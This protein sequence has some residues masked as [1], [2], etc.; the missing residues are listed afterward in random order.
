MMKGQ[1]DSKDSY[2]Q[3][4]MKDLLKLFTDN[5]EDWIDR[6]FAQKLIGWLD[7]WNCEFDRNKFE[8]SIYTIWE[9]EF[10][11]LLLLNANLAEHE[12]VAITNHAFF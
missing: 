1:Q 6:E 7:K 11:K 8:P 5:R 4:V 10:Q 2:V 12:H 9:H 3:L